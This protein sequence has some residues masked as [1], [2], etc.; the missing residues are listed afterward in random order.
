MVKIWNIIFMD[1]LNF[2]HT[3]YNVAKKYKSRKSGPIAVNPNILHISQ[4]LF[5]KFTKSLRIYSET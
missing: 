1:F 5:V 4:K 2:K 3:I